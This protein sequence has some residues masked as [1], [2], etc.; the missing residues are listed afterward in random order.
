VLHYRG[1]TYNGKCF[2][3]KDTTADQLYASK[4][5]SLI[6]S[7]VKHAV[8]DTWSWRLF[9]DGKFPMT[10]YRQGPK[11]ECAANAGYRLY[12]RSAKRCAHEG[13]DAERILQV[14]YTAKL[15]K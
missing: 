9:R 7:R 10:G 4:S 2:D 5:L 1:G 6:P 13:W 12:V 15:V 3:V 8:N 14:Y 11:V